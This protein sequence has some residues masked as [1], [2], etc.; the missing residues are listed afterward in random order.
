MSSDIYKKQLKKL[1]HE[2]ETIAIE[3]ALPAIVK[4]AL[5]HSF[6][7]VLSHISRLEFEPEA[8]RIMQTAARRSQTLLPMLEPYFRAKTVRGFADMM[9]DLERQLRLLHYLHR[10]IAALE[11]ALSQTEYPE[12]EREA[13]LKVLHQRAGKA[14][15]RLQ[16][17]LHSG[18]FRSFARD[19]TRFLVADDNG[20]SKN[21]ALL[22]ARHAIPALLHQAS[23][24]VRA[25]YE[26]LSEQDEASAQR[27]YT[28]CLALHDTIT[29]AQPILGA[30]M[31]D[32]VAKLEAFMDV[33]EPLHDYALTTKVLRPSKKL[34]A[35][36]VDMLDTYRTNQQRKLEATWAAV[37]DAWNQYNTRT[38]QRKFSDALLVLR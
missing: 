19:Y 2:L 27:L 3:D 23:A 21:G 38:N 16:N 10:N 24:H 30:S 33:L 35:M 4:R 17:L 7:M 20:E 37:A 13:L 1:D 31:G 25:A 14:F 32:F 9:D 28:R 8:L 12:D 15:K 22:E 5:R 6:S 26:S 11:D 36:Q 29:L 34:S 18:E